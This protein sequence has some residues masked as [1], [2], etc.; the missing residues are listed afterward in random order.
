MTAPSSW[1]DLPVSL[2]AVIL[3]GKFKELSKIIFR[4][5][6]FSV[7]WLHRKPPSSIFNSSTGVVDCAWIPAMF[8]QHS[9]A[10]PETWGVGCPLLRERVGS[11]SPNNTVLGQETVHNFCRDIRLW[12]GR[13]GLTVQVRLM[14]KEEGSQYS[15]GNKNR[16]ITCGNYATS[17]SGLIYTSGYVYA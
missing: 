15:L 16:N 14:R 3:L 2:A 13:K 12:L 17:G 1:T 9:N 5:K 4:T 8:I 10:A 7:I 11:L 6:Y